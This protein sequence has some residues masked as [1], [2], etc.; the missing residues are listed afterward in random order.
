MGGKTLTGDWL[1][2]GPTL[3][4]STYGLTRS[5]GDLTL[6]TTERGANLYLSWAGLARDASKGNS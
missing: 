6:V 4:P 5:D 2:L 3:K 1:F